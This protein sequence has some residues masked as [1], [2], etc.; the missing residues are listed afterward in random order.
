[1]DFDDEESSEYSLP[2]SSRP[3]PTLRIRG[4]GWSDHDHLINGHQHHRHDAISEV[5][6]LTAAIKHLEKTINSHC[7]ILSKKLKNNRSSTTNR[8]TASRPS[9]VVRPPV[10]PRNSVK[11]EKTTVFIRVVFLKIGEIDTM[12]ENFAADAFIQAR[13]RECSLDKLQGVKKEAAPLVGR[14]NCKQPPYY[15]QYAQ[16]VDDIDWDKYWNPKLYVENNLGEPK[17][18][19]WQTCTWNTHGEAMVYERR[20]IKGCFLEN[21][22]LDEFPFDTQDLTLTVTSERAE[23]EVD[24]EE[25][26]SELSSINIQSFVDEQE[27]RLHSHVETWK[28]VT[29]RIYQN[30][31][32]KH[33]ALSTSCRA[34]RRPGF[35]VWNIFLVMLF[36]CSLAFATFTVDL[37]LPQNRLQLSFILLLT[38]ITFKFVVSQTLPRIS[39]LT[40]LDKYILTSMAILCTVCVWHSVVPLV[41]YNMELAKMIDRCALIILGTGYFLFHAVFFLYIYFVALKKRWTYNEKD[42]EHKE[43]MRSSQAKL[44]DDVDPTNPTL[45]I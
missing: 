13:W 36:I 4:V 35:F 34:S 11:A 29:T 43:R 3:T 42:R 17:E 38:T 7:D 28:R 24:L 30:S 22:E 41:E 16:S 19:I 44:Q 6:E 26:N 14:N 21:L 25:D 33:P 15:D 20:R 40:Y 10:S 31:K 18:V 12:K 8:S 45:P 39:Y 1:M 32:F 23:A 2:P 9:L 5:G 37:R 27:W